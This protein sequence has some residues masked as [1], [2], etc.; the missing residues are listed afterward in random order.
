MSQPLQLSINILRKETKA[1]HDVMNKTK[2][3]SLTVVQKACS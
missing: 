1:H 3:Q 2:F